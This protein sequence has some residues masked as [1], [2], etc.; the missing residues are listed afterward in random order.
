LKII[1]NKF[2]DKEIIELKLKN[3]STYN[4]FTI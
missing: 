1:H 3:I 2:S 4:K